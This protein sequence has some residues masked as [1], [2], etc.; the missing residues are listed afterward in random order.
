VIGGNATIESPSRSPGR[1]AATVDARDEA[2]L[3]FDAHWFPG[4]R[5]TI[6]GAAHAI[7]PGL[8]NFDDGGLIR[9]RVP[10]GRHTVALRYGR[11]PLRWACDAISL[12][13]LFGVVA[14]F[15]VSACGARRRRRATG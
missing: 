8:D 7:G 4:W 1:Y 6:D 5:A 2:L 12:L 14:L 13:A 15:G 3:E 9:V 10:P 11:T